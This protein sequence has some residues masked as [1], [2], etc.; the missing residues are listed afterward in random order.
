MKGV[1]QRDFVVGAVQ[2]E[3]KVKEIEALQLPVKADMS[4]LTGSQ[5]TTVYTTSTG[6]DI[7]LTCTKQQLQSALLN[8]RHACTLSKGFQKSRCHLCQ[9]GPEHRNKHRDSMNRWSGTG[10]AYK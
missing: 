2:I 10:Q 6:T 1:Y 4:M 5:W 7:W 9:W 8:A 3:A